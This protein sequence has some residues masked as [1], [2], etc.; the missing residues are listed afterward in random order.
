MTIVIENKTDRPLNLGKAAGKMLV[1]APNETKE[2][3]EKLA[4]AHMS[5]IEKYV[6]GNFLDVITKA[7]KAVVVDEAVPTKKTVG[8]T[9]KRVAKE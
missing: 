6:D 7:K 4:A 2:L 3:S 5:E 1:F 8:R 9:R